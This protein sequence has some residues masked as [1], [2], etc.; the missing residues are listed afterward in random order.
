MVQQEEPKLTE[1]LPEAAE[2]FIT[3]VVRKMR[4]RRKVRQEVR[5]ELTAHLLDSLRDCTDAQQRNKQV[6]ELL[7]EFGDVKMLAI[8]LRR[9]KKRCRPAWR[10][11]V[12]RMFQIA[13]AALLAFVLYAVWF[14][15][16][17][18]TI[19]TDYLAMM[20]EKTRPQVADA[21]NAWACYDKA[22]GLFKAPSDMIRQTIG[23]DARE[24]DFVRIGEL[25][26]LLAANRQTVARYV[27]D[28]EPRIA[29]LDS[30]L[31]AIADEAFAR[32]LMPL[33]AGGEPDV[34]SWRRFDKAVE[35]LCY[36]IQQAVQ[37]GDA[38]S[39]PMEPVFGG[40]GREEFACDPNHALSGRLTTW[41]RQKTQPR[42]SAAQ[43]ALDAAAMAYWLD[44]PQP[45][46]DTVLANLC[47]YEIEAMERWVAD[48]EAAWAAF[49][50]G[51]LRRY[52]YRPYSLVDG[53][54]RN[55]LMAVEIP[56]LGSLRDLA[57]LGQWRSRLALREGTAGAALDNCAAVA[58]AARH[59]QD[60][61]TIIEQLVGA[62]MARLARDQVLE[63]LDNAKPSAADIDRTTAAL[64]GLYDQGY[65]VLDLEFERMSLM[66]IIQHVFTDGGPG[67]GHL[68]G[69]EVLQ[70]EHPVGEDLVAR[71]GVKAAGTALGIV[72]ARRNATQAM[73]NEMFDNAVRRSK[74]T[75]FERRNSGIPAIDQLLE[76]RHP[77][78]YALL[79]M[80]LPALDRAS[81]LAFQSRAM[82][83]ATLT[84]LALQRRH[85]EKGAYPETLSVLVDE[86][87]LDQLP[88]DPFSD[89]P[90]VYRRTADGFIL[91][92]VWTDFTD[93]GGTTLY[94]HSGRPKVGARDDGADW[95][96]W[97]I[98]RA[99]PVDAES[100]Q[101]YR[102][103][104]QESRLLVAPR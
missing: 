101:A 76:S 37:Q 19:R 40:Y 17:R 47:P 49:V 3:A 43:K 60:K 30:E 44:H 36:R 58:R 103:E 69:Q 65:P 51:G 32:G 18:P 67:G 68:I 55:W 46:V 96:Y 20:N 48:N 63:I 73:A 71:A 84:I 57:R 42:R 82:H 34:P 91:Y 2:A 89:K 54:D 104:Q 6:R 56:H 83:E 92:S 52:C 64:K 77:Y 9:A 13:A 99:R 10:T 85:A 79:H 90:L 98:P 31:K 33:V 86:K 80:M 11:A 35:A 22:I 7:T 102:R 100:R 74:L 88:M 1:T 26:A 4:Y 5:E 12:V 14:S 72:H 50:E 45:P 66:D 29:D 87:W 97:P 61:G 25:E 81:E 75:P 16:G 28:N 59:W 8:L 21:D 94:G 23:K 15:M 39:E 78:R 95:V 53:A 62:S 27:Q 41:A 38:P 93:N 24:P 70:F